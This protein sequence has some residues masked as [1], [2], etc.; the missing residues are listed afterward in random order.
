MISLASASDYGIIGFK[1]A[2]NVSDSDCQTNENFTACQY[3]TD[4]FYNT[5]FKLLVNLKVEKFFKV[6]SLKSQ[7]TYKKSGNYKL[8]VCALN[9]SICFKT[10][11][12]VQDSLFL[13]FLF[14][15]KFRMNFNIKLK[16]FYLLLFVR[17]KTVNLFH[18]VQI[19]VSIMFAII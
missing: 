15:F 6:F 9:R 8:E 7:N 12:T 11:L 18:V 10:N 4:S 17:V 19:V 2:N 13:F 14:Y 16:R 3:L 5:Y 1:L